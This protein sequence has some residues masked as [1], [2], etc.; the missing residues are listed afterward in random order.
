MSHLQKAGL[1]V[2][3]A[4]PAR[5]S[6]AVRS[7]WTK[8]LRGV[9]PSGQDVGHH[10]AAQVRHVLLGETWLGAEGD[11][12]RAIRRK[13]AAVKAVGLLRCVRRRRDHGPARRL[14]GRAELGLVLVAE[15]AQ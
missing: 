13:D 15:V 12:V 4:V 10:A 9:D 1:L 8:S 7:T 3:L 14:E 6:L 2:A 5:G 11:V